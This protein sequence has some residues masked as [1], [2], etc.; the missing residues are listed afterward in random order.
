MG[1]REFWRE[2]VDYLSSKPFGREILDKLLRDLV[3]YALEA[4][5]REDAL[6]KKIALYRSERSP[7]D[8]LSLLNSLRGISHRDLDLILASVKP[9]KVSE[10]TLLE[11]LT[12]I[13]RVEKNAYRARR[14]SIRLLASYL[15][16]NPEGFIKA[17]ELIDA[18]AAAG[19]IEA[20]RAALKILRGSPKDSLLSQAIGDESLYN[21]PEEKIPYG[22]MIKALSS[23]SIYFKASRKKKI[24]IDTR[25]VSKCIGKFMRE[26]LSAR[27]KPHTASF[28][29]RIRLLAHLSSYNFASEE[30][31]VSLLEL[32]KLLSEVISSDSS[33]IFKR[34]RPVLRGILDKAN[35]SGVTITSKDRL[36]QA[37]ISPIEDRLVGIR[38]RGREIGR[39]ATRLLSLLLPELKDLIVLSD[40]Y[41]ETLYG[42][43][44]IYPE[45]IYVGRYIHVGIEAYLY[46]NESMVK[47]KNRIFRRTLTN[48]VEKFI[49]DDL[50]KAKAY[51]RAISILEGRSFL[52]GLSPEG[53]RRYESSSLYHQIYPVIE[54]IEDR[55][56][57]M[58]AFMRLLRSSWEGLLF[59]TLSM[60]I[61]N[62]NYIR[63]T[64]QRDIEDLV[65][66]IKAAMH[67]LLDQENEI[68]K[69][70]SLSFS[71]LSLDALMAIRRIASI[72]NLPAEASSK[73]YAYYKSLEPLIEELV[74]LSLEASRSIDI[75]RIVEYPK[76]YPIFYLVIRR[77]QI[78]EGLRRS[79]IYAY[80]YGYE[81]LLE[82][83]K[84]YLD[85]RSLTAMEPRVIRE[86]PDV[87]VTVLPVIGGKKRFKLKIGTQSAPE[88]RR[89][90]L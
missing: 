34:I 8:T 82:A 27:W 22:A 14:S 66:I 47:T 86:D 81:D 13:R 23:L 39:I 4:P 85:S 25:S 45:E 38:Y 6:L 83:F 32:E 69:L 40:E 7:E 24:K 15:L 50:S 71:L 65:P 31:P 29:D 5:E 26:Y 30:Y 74:P 17:D 20:Y 10:E 53:I 67:T 89:R 49:E 21:L 48:L 76:Y 60:R 63:S 61:S 56:V 68:V 1:I 2:I 88:S 87:I 70:I 62:A 54:L 64:V 41:P 46:G 44:S 84:E 18:S 42:I 28:F 11:T 51:S 79:A 3:R 12:T 90:L 77:Y 72:R 52:R 43:H 19:D 58:Y 78:I 9:L 73:V 36:P 33:E 35:A 55:L 75:F 59:K 16:A 57:R 80:F 37:F